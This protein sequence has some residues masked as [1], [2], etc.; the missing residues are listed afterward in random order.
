MIAKDMNLSC[1]ETEVIQSVACLN[2]E[3]IL[4]QKVNEGLHYGYALKHGKNDP[5][6]E[7]PTNLTPTFLQSVDY[8]FG[9]KTVGIPLTPILSC[10]PVSEIIFK[11]LEEEEN[12]WTFMNDTKCD[13]GL[14]P[15]N[16]IGV[17]LSALLSK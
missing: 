14:S 10:E 13:R 9:I 16:L 8:G 7:M 17:I 12:Y 4:I 1:A 11:A 5:M 15:D 6:T 2:P 3:D